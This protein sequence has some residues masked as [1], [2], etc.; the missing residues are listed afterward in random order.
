MVPTSSPRHLSSVL[1]ELTPATSQE[2]QTNENGTG[3]SRAPEQPTIPLRRSLRKRKNV[4][5]VKFFALYES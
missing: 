1:N 3:K 2:N 5:E 4:V